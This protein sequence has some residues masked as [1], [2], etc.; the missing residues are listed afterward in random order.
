MKHLTRIVLLGLLSCTCFACDF[1]NVIDNTLQIPGEKVEHVALSEDEYQVLN[2]I[3]T[4]SNP[5]MKKH[6]E[7]YEKLS[8]EVILIGSQQDLLYY[9]PDSI[10]PP[11]ID[12][13]NHCLI[14]SIVST[15][16]IQSTIRTVELYLQDNGT[17]TFYTNIKAA[18]MDNLVSLAF[19]YGVFDV[20]E[21]QIKQL[22][23]IARRSWY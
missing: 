8:E 14:F 18:S 7:K 5:I 4:L 13:K 17:A 6:V 23:I 2:Q 1:L 9:C 21:E 10:T 22:K 12:F 16:T 3:F 20:P 11:E 19:P 15:P